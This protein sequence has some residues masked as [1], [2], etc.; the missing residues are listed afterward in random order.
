MGPKVA[1]P[2]SISLD[3][4]GGLCLTDEGMEEDSTLVTSHISRLVAYIMSCRKWNR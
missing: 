4:L 1:S 3:R 2:P